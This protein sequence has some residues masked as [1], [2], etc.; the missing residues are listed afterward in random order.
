MKLPVVKYS[1][2]WAVFETYQEE[3]ENIEI[4]I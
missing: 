4:L 2:D 1:P 3:K